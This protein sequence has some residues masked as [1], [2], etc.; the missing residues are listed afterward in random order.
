MEKSIN[1]YIKTHKLDVN[2]FNK[3]IFVKAL[4]MISKEENDIRLIIKDIDMIYANYQ[5][6]YNDNATPLYNYLMNKLTFM[7]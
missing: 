3:E 2:G 4:C 6:R 5:I 1:E 7:P